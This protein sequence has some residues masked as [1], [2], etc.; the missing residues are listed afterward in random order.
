[1]GF[2]GAGGK[3]IPEKNQKQNLGH[4]PFKVFFCR[5][6]T[7]VRL[8]YT[9]VIYYLL[10]VKAQRIPGWAM[11]SLRLESGATSL[12]TRREVTLKQPYS[13]TRESTIKRLLVKDRSSISAL[14]W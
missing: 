7:H 10:A 4:C 5:H 12:T 9:R 14:R 13:V 11:N 2:S 1:M 6:L 3:L 8:K